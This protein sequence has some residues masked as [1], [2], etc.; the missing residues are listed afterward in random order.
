MK[1]H[2]FTK[3]F[4]E[5]GIKNTSDWE[6]CLGEKFEDMYKCIANLFNDFLKRKRPDE[7][8]TEDDFVRPVLEKLGFRFSRQKS[9]NKRE[10]EDIPDFILFVSDEDKEEF[11][12]ASEKP[13]GKGIAILEG[14]RWGR[15]LDKG[16][17]T[18]PIDPQV[19]SHQILRYLSSTEIASNGKILWGI[20]TNGKVWRLY[21]QRFPSRIDGYI[22][23]DLEDIF[24][25]GQQ[26]LFGEES[27]KLEKGDLFKLFYLFFRKEAFITTMRR[28]QYSFLELALN[29]GKKWE[30]KVSEDLKDKIF[31]GVFPDI[32]RGFLEDAKRKGKQLDDQ[33]LKEIYENTLVFLYRVLFVLYAEDRDLLPVSSQPYQEYSFSKIRNDIA[34]KIDSKKFSETATTYWDRIK[35][36]FK[37]ISE[38]DKT[39]GIPPYNGELFKPENHPFLENFAVADKLLTPAIDKLSRHFSSFSPKRINYRD[40]S[41]RQLGSIY[42]GLLEFKLQIAKTH[43][44]VKKEK[45]REIYAETH[46]ELKAKVKKG[47]LYLTNDKSERKATGSYYTPDYIVRYIVKNTLEPLIQEYYKEFEDWENEIS[48]QDKKWIIKQ[49][50]KYRVRFDPKKYDKGG[51]V[52][53]EKSIYEYR[54]A[55]LTV[56]D[57][58]VAI[59]SLKLLDPAIGSGHF[60]VGAVDHLADKI[61]EILAEISGKSFFG[62]VPY[63]S[64]LSKK[65]E[66]IRNKIKEKAQ[67]EEYKINE[68]HLEDKNLIKR[69][70]LK[71]CIYGVDVNP[72]AVE[73]AEVSLWLHTFTVGAPLSFLDHHIKCGNS[74]IGAEPEDFDTVLKTASMFSFQYTGL[75]SAV[76]MIKQLE[77]IADLDISEVEESNKIYQSVINELDPYKKLLD[78]YVVDQFLRPEKKSE[79]KNYRSSLYLI[80]G[81]KGDPIQIVKGEINLPEDE[82]GL[83]DKALS[84]AK[85]KRFFHWKLEFPEIWYEGGRGK[86]NG[87]FDAVIG[88]PPYIKA[89]ESSGRLLMER[90]VLTQLGQY[91]WLTKKWDFYVAFIERAVSLLR[92]SGLTSYII[93]DVIDREE[94]A[95]KL[96]E[97]VTKKLTILQLDYFPQVEL[98]KNVGIHNIVFLFKKSPPDD[99]WVPLRRIHQDE[100]T[101]NY[102]ELPAYYQKAIGEKIFRPEY[103]PV[104]EQNH[105]RYLPISSIFYISVGMVLNADEK[106]ARGRFKK[107]DLLSTRNDT[108]HTKAFADNQSVSKYLITINRYLEWDTDR[109]PNMVRRPTFPELHEGQ[110]LLFTR[111]GKGAFTSD[112]IVCD[113][114]V[115]ILKPWWSIASVKNKSIEDELQDVQSRYGFTIRELADLSQRY[116]LQY[117]LSLLNCTV[118]VTT[119]LG[120]KKRDRYDLTPDT[121]RELPIRQINFTTPESDRKQLLEKGI[122]LCQ[123]CLISN[124]WSKILSFVSECLPQKADGA[125]DTEHEKS[126]VVHDL[127]AFLAEEMTRLNEEKQSRIKSF[128]TWLEKEILKGSVEKQKNKTRMKDFHNRT[129]EDLLNV[130]K[131]NKAVKDP[132]ASGV[133]DTIANEFSAA[134]NTL[135][136]LKACI[137]ATDDLIDQIVYRLYGFTEAEVAIVEE[138]KGLQ[139]ANVKKDI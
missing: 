103:V 121:I 127:L 90:K 13:W 62:K 30:E 24:G 6:E 86:E 63:Q 72:L 29:E 28:P 109:V 49:L 73:L 123:E 60:L 14:K 51:K 124:D 66:E 125:P 133:R 97:D 129:F 33:L 75:L 108:V 107:E 7:A 31:Y 23:I 130:L 10:R 122:R 2:L 113:Q 114:R 48:K 71:R 116:D 136:P 53:D 26:P 43:F 102:E 91:V 139:A 79:L 93:P 115:I 45:G 70:I 88:N 64:P 50:D 16:D 54:N 22:E 134:V 3:Y 69:I 39:L 41:V 38:G 80:D 95:A 138:S 11:D 82:K 9:P 32:A 78:I 117:I 21:Y 59:L 58:A 44:E 99:C 77:E 12:C 17:K 104:T 96:R 120:Q 84:L 57:P 42:E 76:G 47:E 61:I 128:L 35:N 92:E 87:G 111:S 135:T 81:I 105:A 74:L 34:S 46:D 55:L 68:E 25:T 8:D 15:A 126:D 4:L 137:K 98:F 5:E 52:I 65:L 1:G 101:K 89:N 20:L 19:P 132:C 94:Y 40:L 100:T 37:I 106:K 110:R 18:D 56:K 67:Q 85:E 112:D 131:K 27:P 36:L 119:F 83:L 118:L